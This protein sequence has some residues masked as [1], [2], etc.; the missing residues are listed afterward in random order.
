MIGTNPS[1]PEK[2]SVASKVK[3]RG[4]CYTQ[5]WSG[6]TAGR[7]LA[8]HTVSLGSISGTPY[9]VPDLALSEVIPELRAQSQE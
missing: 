8:L 3:E 2:G 4:G 1:F 6:S 5:D 9:G 7:A